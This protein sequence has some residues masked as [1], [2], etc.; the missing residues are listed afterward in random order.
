MNCGF[1]SLEP[2]SVFFLWK[3]NAYISLSMFGSVAG[4]IPT[5]FTEF[6]Q[7]IQSS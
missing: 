5:I 2:D 1:D 7:R 3:S 4:N 6:K